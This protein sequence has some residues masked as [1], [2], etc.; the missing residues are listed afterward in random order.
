LVVVPREQIFQDASFRPASR[1][2]IRLGA[3]ASGR[4]VAAVH[5]LDQQT[6][7]HDLFPWSC[8]E[9]TAGLYA[10]DNFRG[11]ERLVRTDVQT[12][13]SATPWPRD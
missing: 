2:R 9:I 10:M 8:T 6:S 3:E 5:E 12:P 11:H 7:R 4:L 1:H 13:G